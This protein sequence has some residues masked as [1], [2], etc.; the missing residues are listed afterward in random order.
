MEEDL[1]PRDIDFLSENKIDSWGEIWE[2]A[3]SNHSIHSIDDNQS[4]WHL[5]RISYLAG[6]LKAKG[7]N[8]SDIQDKLN[9]YYEEIKN[10]K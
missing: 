6:F 4:H 2:N 10:A 1:R 3:L 9:K 5:S 7:M 8:D